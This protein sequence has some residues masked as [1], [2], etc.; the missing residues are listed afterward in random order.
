MQR[1]TFY[2]IFVLIA[3][4]GAGYFFAFSGAKRNPFP[5][6]PAQTLQ[7]SAAPSPETKQAPAPE[8]ENEK[9]TLQEATPKNVVVT[10]KKIQQEVPF[11]VQA[12]FGNWKNP[13]F[14]NA[15]EEASM[16]MAIGW[17]EGEKTISPAEAQK[18]ILAIIDFENKT[19]G[20]S[21]G[22]NAF[23]M[24][25]VFQQYFKHKNISVKEDITVEELKAEI[26]KGNLVIVPAFGRALKNPNFTSPGPVAH[27]LVIIGYDQITQEFITN[28]PGTRNGAG[29]RYDEKLLFDSIWS[30]P[31]GK[32][33]PPLPVVDKMKKIMI[34]I[35]N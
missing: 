10:D 20:Y 16:I 5:Q 30:Y 27:M 4:L 1:K 13:D 3:C 22:T 29:Y 21:T 9:A 26:Q 7:K 8:K 33:D 17:A 19:F 25:K 18:R 24:E 11:I 34:S 28:D 12:P 2:I 35:S 6:N 31:S 15:C 32:S 14:Q 23:D